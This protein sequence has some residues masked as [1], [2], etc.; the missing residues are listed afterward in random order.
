MP[1]GEDEY[2]ANNDSQDRRNGHVLF[3][4]FHCYA[5]MSARDLG[6]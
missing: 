2:K 3:P 1:A 6:R 5:A 4:S